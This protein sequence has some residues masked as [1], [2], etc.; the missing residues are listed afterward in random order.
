MFGL[1]PPSPGGFIERFQSW[2]VGADPGQVRMRMA[3]RVTLTLVLVGVLMMLVNS[4]L[5]LPIVSFGIGLILAF[6][7]AIAIKDR[8]ASGRT[9]TRILCAAAGIVVIAAIAALGQR[10][11]VLDG[12]FLVVTFAAVYA[13]KWGQRWNAAGMFAFMACFI[14]IY[15]RSTW[16]DLPS[17]ALALVL[18]GTVAH[19]VREF[20]LPDRAAY[21]FAQTIRAVEERIGAL[22]SRIR[23]G[24]RAGWPEEARRAT[25]AAEGKVKSAIAIAEGLLPDDADGAQ[26]N[27]LASTLAIKLFDLHLATETAL[28]AALDQGDPAPYERRLAGTLDRLAKARLDLKRSV[29]GLDS[30]QLEGPGLALPSAPIARTPWYRQA[31]FRL[32]VQVTLACALAMMGG[33]WVS[34]QRWFWAVL[35]AFLVFVNTQSRGDAVLRSIDRALGTAAGIVVGIL[36]A[37]LLHQSFAIS[38]A[39]IVV[40]VFLAFYF[41]QLSY[42]ALTFFITVALSLVYGLLGS[43]SPDLLV[44]RLKETLVGALAGMAVSFFVFPTRTE[45]ISRRGVDNFLGELDRLLEAVLENRRGNASPWKV[46]AVTRALDRRHTDIVATVRPLESGWISAPRRK[47]VRLGLLRLAALAYWAHRLAST[48]EARQG[49]DTLPGDDDIERSIAEC[50]AEIAA[51]RSGVG[52]FF[53]QSSPTALSP[54]DTVSSSRDLDTPDAALA[55]HALRHILHQAASSE[56]QEP[57]ARSKPRSRAV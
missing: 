43:F 45:N 3:G 52:H 51:L 23:A 46:L 9:R 47:L 30:R 28:A 37:T 41:V 14:G 7:N 2:L 17:V 16:S 5:P 1:S 36:V 40:C 44:L 34:D 8:S 39:V 42:G 49:A 48:A 21:D 56:T 54:P 57:A 53:R 35:T 22:V 15:F 10:A 33:Y 12:F 25:I 6:Q 31:A 20:V 13:R 29:E 24:K 4:V 50:R 32:A 19:L 55:L 26:R 38:I 18:C 11:I 27:T